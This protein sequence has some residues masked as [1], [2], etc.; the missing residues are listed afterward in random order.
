MCECVCVC[1]CVCV[2][3]CV[4]E[5]ERERERERVVPHCGLEQG[6][7]TKGEGSVQLTP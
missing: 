6:T 1:Q 3:V 4:S 7:L 5:R 2:S